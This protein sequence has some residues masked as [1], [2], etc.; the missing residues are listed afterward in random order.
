MQ[1]SDNNITEYRKSEEK[2]GI[3][4]QERFSLFHSISRGPQQG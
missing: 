1:K 3:I 2:K 4:Y